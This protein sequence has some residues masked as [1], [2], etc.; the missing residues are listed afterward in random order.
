[1]PHQM[2]NDNPQSY[3]DLLVDDMLKIRLKMKARMLFGVIPV[4]QTAW[5]FSKDL[6]SLPETKQSNQQI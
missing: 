3:S 1:M 6:K 2:V 4:R 5:I